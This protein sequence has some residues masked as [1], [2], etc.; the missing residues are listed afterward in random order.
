MTMY[1]AG[2]NAINILCQ[3]LS[4]HLKSQGHNR[5]GHTPQAL[6]LHPSLQ[7]LPQLQEELDPQG[8]IFEC[9]Q[10]GGVWYG[11]PDWWLRRLVR[12]LDCGKVECLNSL[13]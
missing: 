2:S 1:S 8:H 5:T 10:E 12:G 3:Y 9:F 13:F 4:S 7:E 6:Q 11:W